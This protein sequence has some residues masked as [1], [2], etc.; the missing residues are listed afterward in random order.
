MRL[1]ALVEIAGV[2]SYAQFV[3]SM[4]REVSLRLEWYEH[5]LSAPWTW[6]QETVVDDN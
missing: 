1:R 6:P 2:I 4:D 5:G 3:P